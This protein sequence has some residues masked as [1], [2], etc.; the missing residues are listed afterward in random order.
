MWRP[1]LLSQTYVFFDVDDTLVEW[2]VRWEKVFAQAACEA[3]AE[4]APQQ[5]WDAINTAFSTFY[6]D[7]L[8]KHSEAG[9]EQEFWLDYNGRILE[10]LGVRSEPGR[11]AA[12][13]TELLKKQDSVRL[14]PE[15]QEVLQTLAEGGA[16]LGIITGRPRA[17]PDLEA[18]GVRHHFDLVLD[19]LSAGETKVVGSVMFDRAVGAVAAAGMTGWHVGDSYEHDV[20][21]AQAAGLRGVLVDRDGRHEEADCPRI[22]DL[23][24]LP[25]MI[26]RG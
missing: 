18:L 16:R 14:F 8:K 10:T 11:A 3:G 26:E 20:E 1:I 17:G 21:A 9:D 15:V 24:A 2:T 6:G 22:E 19:G 25:E 12:R 4:V 23:R 7:Y 5:A 13:V